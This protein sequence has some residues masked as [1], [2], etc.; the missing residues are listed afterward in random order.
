MLGIPVKLIGKDGR[1]NG[2]GD[3]VMGIRGDLVNILAGERVAL[4]ILSRMSGIATLTRT[5]VER[6]RSVNPDIRIA[7]SRKTTPGFRFFE[8]KAV[9]LGGG[10]THRF[11]L[12]DCIMLKD[13]HIRKLTSIQ[14]GVERART[15]SFT[16]KVEVEVETRE[17]AAEAAR[18]GADIIMLDNMDPVKAGECY[19]MLKEMQPNVIVEVSGGI[20]PDTIM[21]Y[22]AN[23]DVISLGYL[24]HSYRSVD[25]SLEV[26]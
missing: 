17:Q 11:R 13:N 6:T 7:C 25:F 16:K 23:A 4:N 18:A 14:E 5:L 19:G 24:T 8:K 12:D 2:S 26:L 21:E 22:A 20:T 10:D 9:M 15:F 1:R 3:V